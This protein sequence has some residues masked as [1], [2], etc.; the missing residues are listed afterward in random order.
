MSEIKLDLSRDNVLE[1]IDQLLYH[2][3]SRV[4]KP[5]T[6]LIINEITSSRIL[7][8]A[9]HDV[10]GMLPFKTLPNK[11]LKYININGVKLNIIRTRDIDENLIEI[12]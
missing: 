4:A 9:L 3:L 5:P 10:M 1:F 12:L 2:K 7:E 6:H 11:T 8:P